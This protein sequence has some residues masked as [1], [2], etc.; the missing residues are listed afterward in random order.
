[1]Q[2]K[3]RPTIIDVALAAGVGASTV[4]RHV[5]GGK[6]VSK[7]V[8]KRIDAAIAEL[9][10]EPN[11]LARGLRVGRSRTIGVLFPHVNNI[12]FG[13]AMRMIQAAAQR[14]GF[15][16]ML[17][18]HQEDSKLQQEQL[19]SLKRSQVDGIILVP[20][21]GSNVA[22]VRGLLGKTPIVAFDRPLGGSVDSVTLH[23]RAAGREATEHL[24]WHKQQRILAITA[25]HKLQPLEARLKG[26]EEAMEAAGRQ[27]ETIVWQDSLQLRME[28]SHALQRKRAPVTAIVSMSYSVTIAILSALRYVN[29]SLRDVGFIGIDD[30]E[31]ASFL[32]PAL[33]TVIQPAEQFGQLAFEQLMRRIGGSEDVAV[34]I[35]LPGLLAVRASCGCE[36]VA[37]FG[38]DA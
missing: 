4:S 22:L 6:S 20:A 29:V 31:F 32:D 37:E 36:P 15:T 38:E 2:E 19:I 25:P 7:R 5:R 1:M 35:A 27:P 33:T 11:S 10:Y 12:F 24:L 30:L 14:N 8:A 17:L 13:N 16:V 18:M 3:K 26:Y 34:K 21:A 9:G 28:L 23:N